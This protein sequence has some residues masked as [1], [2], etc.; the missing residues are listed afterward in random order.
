MSKKQEAAVVLGVA[1]VG[2]AMAH[3]VAQKQAAVLG[4]SAF[5]L[6][7]IGWFVSEAIG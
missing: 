3:R 7:V 5:T 1:L 4:I 2:G 6:A